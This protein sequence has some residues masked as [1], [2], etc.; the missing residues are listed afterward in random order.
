MTD[1]PEPLRCDDC[2]RPAEWVGAEIG[3]G[4][5]ARLD[6]LCEACRARRDA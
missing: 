1:D 2:G 5:M 4:A 6:Y 3:D